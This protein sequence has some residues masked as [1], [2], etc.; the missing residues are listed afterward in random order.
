MKDALLPE[1]DIVQSISYNQHEILDDII[2]L[3]CPKTGIELDPTYNVGGFYVSG[4]PRP[5]YCFD[6]KPLRPET[7]KAD[8]RDLPLARG[9]IRAAIFDPPFFVANGK[10][11]EKSLMAL[12]YSSVETLEELWHLYE[13]SLQEFYRVLRIHGVLIFKCQDF[14]LGRRNIFSHVW[15]CNKAEE[16]G[17]RPIDMF[18]KL[19]KNA[20]VPGNFKKQQHARKMHSYFWVFRK[21]P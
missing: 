10:S 5:R 3:Y 14:I 13:F 1:A 19:N 21:M 8:C 11:A 6:I 18:I 20:M 4:I 12:K 15:V 16:V 7:Q 2:R 9:S 17:F